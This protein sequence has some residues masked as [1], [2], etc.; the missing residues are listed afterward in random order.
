MKRLFLLMLIYLVILI[1]GLMRTYLRNATTS[2]GSKF[3]VTRGSF[4]TVFSLKDRHILWSIETGI[5]STNPWVIG[6]GL[7]EVVLVAGSEQ[8]AAY[9]IVT[10]DL[11]WMHQGFAGSTHMTGDVHHQLYDNRI[12]YPYGS[13]KMDP[14][15]SPVITVSQ[16]S[17][18]S[19]TTWLVDSCTGEELWSRSDDFETHASQFVPTSSGSYDLIFMSGPKF[20]GMGGDMFRIDGATGQKM[21]WSRHFS[22]RSGITIPDITGD[23]QYDFFA[24]PSYWS[25][26]LLMLDGTTGETVWSTPYSSFD[27]IQIPQVVVRED[28]GYDIIVSAQLAS[29][30]GIRRYRTENGAVVWD[31]SHTYNN[32]TI[33]G[34]LERVD[35]MTILSGWRHRGKAVAL[36]ATTGNVLWDDVPLDNSD[37]GAI[38]VPD[39]TNDGN[40]D[41]MAICGGFLRLYDGITGTEQTWFAPIEA[42]G[43][44]CSVSEK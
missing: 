38:G 14:A 12:L 37:T 41:V 29:A 33:I 36:D 10:G 4:V 27:V 17:K 15:S 23:G 31:S 20:T 8:V 26:T 24:E 40:E 43:V 28:G 35:G 39:M 19:S 11:L 7:K 5:E 42:D 34:L 3:I 30:G 32:N 22:N 44:A 2:T 18:V 6:G 9:D 21:L 1:Y 25:S 13:P 16:R